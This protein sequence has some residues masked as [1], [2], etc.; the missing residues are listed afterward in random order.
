MM[1]ARQGTAGIGPERS[2]SVAV[3]ADE[4]YERYLARAIREVNALGDEI[5]RRGDAPTRQPVLGSGHP[6][7]D[8]FLLKHDPTSAELAEG[9]AFYGRVGQAVLK[10]VQRLSID[11]LLVYGTNVV[12]LGGD[13]GRDEGELAERVYP[14]WLL[15]ELHIVQPKIVVVMGEDTLAVV[16]GLDLALSQPLANELGTIQKL[17]PTIEAL[18]TP[19]LEPSL[20]DAAA[21]RAF[22]AAFRALGEWHAALP[23][24]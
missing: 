17:T 6:L 16:N 21:K 15:R 14:M 22:W 9:V 5:A 7:G 12:K 24:Y 10:S 4:L 2:N 19:A 8:I 3:P 20:D 13:H 11:P 18:V 23:P 1:P